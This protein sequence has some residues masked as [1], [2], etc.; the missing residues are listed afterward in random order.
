MGEN[1]IL[2]KFNE[3]ELRLIIYDT[4][5]NV[6]NDLSVLSNNSSNKEDEFLNRVELSKYLK[7]SLSTVDNYTRLGLLKKHKIGHRVL[8]KKNEIDNFILNK[9]GCI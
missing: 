8:F 3:T 4:I 7:I 5:K 1:Y 6:I 9:K 2:T